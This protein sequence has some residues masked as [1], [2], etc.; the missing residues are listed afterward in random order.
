MTENRQPAA[1]GSSQGPTADDYKAEKAKLHSML[2]QRNQIMAKLV[3]VSIMPSCQ[4]HK[5]IPP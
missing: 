5:L 2:S 4:C 1:A 3:S